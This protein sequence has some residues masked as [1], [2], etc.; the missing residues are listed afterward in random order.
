[1]NQIGQQ[2]RKVWST[3]LSS[4]KSSM[5][6]PSP[7]SI[8][9]CSGYKCFQVSFFNQDNNQALTSLV[10]HFWVHVSFLPKRIWLADW[11][12]TLALDRPWSHPKCMSDAMELLLES[13]NI[14]IYAIMWKNIVRKEWKDMIQAQSFLVGCAEGVL[15]YSVLKARSCPTFQHRCR[16]NATPM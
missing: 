14:V 6:S 12:R 3:V 10:H 4:A 7:D 8:R 16:H 15:K 5:V 1:M 9:V 13:N 2:I 11:S